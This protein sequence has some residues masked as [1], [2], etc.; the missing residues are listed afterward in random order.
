V[1]GALPVAL[2]A[3]ALVVSVLGVTPL[4]EAAGDAATSGLAVARNTLPAAVGETSAV[5]GP[6]GPRG[7]RGLRGLRGPRGLQGPQ[8]L[9]GDTGAQGAQGN[10][11]VPG[12]N[13][14]TNEVV[15]TTVFT[16]PNQA[17]GANGGGSVICQ[18]GE[19]A[20]GGGYILNAGGVTELH[21][22]QNAPVHNTLTNKSL[23]WIVTWYSDNSAQNV[24]VYAVCIGP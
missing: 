22:R 15:R 18:P 4:G 20:T 23:G 11:G 2:S 7:P 14:A 8:G 16:S 21:V 3:A 5:R 6:R 17:G 12:S 1:R 10:Q 9:K 24:T 19:T 13:A